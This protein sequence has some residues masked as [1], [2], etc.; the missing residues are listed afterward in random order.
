M[1]ELR[2]DKGQAVYD[3]YKAK[4]GLDDGC[5]LC[6]AKPLKSFKH[7]LIIKNQFPYDKIASVHDM[8][9][10]KR[11]VAER[12][13]SSEERA[14]YQKI[15]DDFLH[16]EYEFMIEATHRKKTIPG[17]FHIHLIVAKS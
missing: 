5:R 17:H 2:T 8:I 11:H 13:I 7:W 4:G 16:K 9:I 15:K 1:G 12:E 3:D 6:E 10:P 14:E